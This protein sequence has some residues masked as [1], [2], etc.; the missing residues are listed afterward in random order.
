M[1]E[2]TAFLSGQSS[3]ADPGYVVGMLSEIKDTAMEDIKVA[4][5]FI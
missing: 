2:V 1:P 3:A 4:F 5:R